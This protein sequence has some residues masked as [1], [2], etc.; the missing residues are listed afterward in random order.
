[1]NSRKFAC[2]SY[3]RMVLLCGFL[4]I[5]TCRAAFPQSTSNQ[6][7]WKQQSITLSVKHQS[8]ASIVE[9]LADKL[10]KSLLVEGE[11][12]R[13]NLD[14]SNT[15]TA[16][17]ILN[18]VADAFDYSWYV[19]KSGILLF[20]KRFH[21]RN[22]YPQFVVP[23]LNE[24][25]ADMFAAMRSLSEFADLSMSIQEQMISIAR[26]LSPQQLEFLKQGGKLRIGIMSEE[27]RTNAEKAIYTH[28]FRNVGRDFKSL[29]EELAGLKTSVL[30]N[31]VSVLTNPFMHTQEKQVG[32]RLLYGASTDRRVLVYRR[33]LT[34]KDSDVDDT[35]AEHGSNATGEIN[36][37]NKQNSLAFNRNA[38][39]GVTTLEKAVQELAQQTGAPLRVAPILASRHLIVQLRKATRIQAMEAFAELEDWNWRT[40]QDKVPTL[41]RPRLPIIHNLE[42][43]RQAIVKVMPADLRRLLISKSESG[44]NEITSAPNS[45]SYLSH[46]NSTRVRVKLEELVSQEGKAL[47]DSLQTEF[48]K[49]NKITYRQLTQEQ[50]TRLST[51]LTLKACASSVE[52]LVSFFDVPT[53][54]ESNPSEA[55]LYFHASGTSPNLVEILIA[56]EE[57]P[58]QRGG[59]FGTRLLLDSLSAPPAP[60]Q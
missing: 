21:N 25:I 60:V 9:I 57:T 52:S 49:Q 44:Q 24:S 22:E 36:G 17:S 41:S 45:L 32:L 33:A 56:G 14:I 58:S 59:A 38:L 40:S 20:Q 16:E 19:S 39:N 53:I 15:G 5:S 2:I 11:P 35:S 47:Y 3:I 8:L 43:I 31:D 12:M 26:S 23:E 1:M 18:Q 4:V 27:Q 54:Y 28:M 46:E 50:R 30:Q 13:Q 7:L 6:D 51:I 37:D 48:S 55:F 10:G 42:E 29:E 34:K